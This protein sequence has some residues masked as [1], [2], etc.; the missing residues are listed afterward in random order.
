[1]LGASIYF[2]LKCEQE[3]SWLDG[4]D[5]CERCSLSDAVFQHLSRVS[6]FVIRPLFKEEMLR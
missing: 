4:G 3:H 6:L 5:N 2:D 1:M